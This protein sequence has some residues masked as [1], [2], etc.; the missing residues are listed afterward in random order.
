MPENPL[1]ISG[2]LSLRYSTLRTLP[3][4]SRTLSLPRLPSF[5]PQLSGTP[6]ADPPGRNPGV[7]GAYSVRSQFS[8]AY[9]PMSENNHCMYFV[10]FLVACS[11]R[12]GPVTSSQPELDICSIFYDILPELDFNPFLFIL[13]F[14]F[15]LWPFLL[16]LLSS[17][18]INLRNSAIPGLNNILLHFF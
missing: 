12:A 1:Q 14:W 6:L 16:W 10:Q 5:C 18:K 15:F 7:L 4:N 9:C 3:Q 11:K 13:S 2:N 8:S 17:L